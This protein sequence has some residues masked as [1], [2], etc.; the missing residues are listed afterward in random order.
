LLA[1]ATSAEHKGYQVFIPGF[2]GNDL[3]DPSWFPP[4]SKEK[5]MA[6]GRFFGP[7]GPANAGVM[8]E[9]LKSV[10]EKIKEENSA[11]TAF[12]VMGY[13]WGA[14]VSLALTK[15]VAHRRFG[16]LNTIC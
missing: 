11:I 3:A 7:K 2:L 8:L 10:V 5:Q 16:A 14:K 1:Y 12:G 4:N 13:C 15:Y 6:M 9:K